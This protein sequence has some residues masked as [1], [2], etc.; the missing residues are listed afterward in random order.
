MS[1]YVELLVWSPVAIVAE[2]GEHHVEAESN[3]RLHCQLRPEAPLHDPAANSTKDQALHHVAMPT[4]L[5]QFAHPFL[6][7]VKRFNF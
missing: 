6:E 7:R 2:G 1:Q 4:V 5:I 3:I